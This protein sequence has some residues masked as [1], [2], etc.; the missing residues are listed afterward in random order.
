[1]VTNEDHVDLVVVTLEEQVQQ[2]EEALGDVLGRLGHGAGDV[3]QAK[4]DC[5][6]AGVGLLDQQV[7]LE[8]EGVEVGHT[9]NACLQ[10]VDFYFQLLNVAEVIR[11]FALHALKLGGRFPELS[12]AAAGQRN[13]PCMRRAQGSDDVDPRRVALVADPGA[14][15]L[16]GVGAGQVALD[17]VRQL[18]VFEHELEKL[19]LSNL[20]RKFIHPFA[21]IARL[22]GAFTASATLRA[23]DVLTGGEFLVARMNNGLLAA[24]TV[25]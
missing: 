10:S 23:G 8:V 3:H 18:Q 13:T 25:M 14:H 5:F 1:M 22:A 16:E 20:K 11:L 19:F 7:V 15:G 4:H 2:N 21:G 17:Q 24:A 9:T 6:G 12:P